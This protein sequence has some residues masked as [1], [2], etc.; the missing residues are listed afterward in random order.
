MKE[1][2][3]ANF[4]EK[5]TW[6]RVRVHLDKQG[7]LDHDFLLRE[8]KL[9]GSSATI[10]TSMRLAVQYIKLRKQEIEK[11]RKAVKDYAIKEWELFESE[12]K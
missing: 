1:Q 3:K 11:L 2:S 9:H 10:R 12:V 8:L 5:T 4:Y 7:I 6:K